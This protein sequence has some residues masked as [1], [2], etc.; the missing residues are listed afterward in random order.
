M[1]VRYCDWRDA[2]EYLSKKKEIKNTQENVSR[3]LRSHIDVRNVFKWYP[4]TA[5]LC[6]CV[7]K[8]VSSLK[9]KVENR[10]QNDLIELNINNDV[11]RSW[12]I[13]VTDEKYSE[14]HSF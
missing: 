9:Q 10:E 4:V 12:K 6:M 1:H 13:Q 14:R 5:L 7:R 2:I 8:E 3:V 11:I